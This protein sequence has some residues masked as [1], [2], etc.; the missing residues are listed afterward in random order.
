MNLY[1]MPRFGEDEE[2][3]PLH[4][5]LAVTDAPPASCRRRPT[6]LAEAGPVRCAQHQQHHSVKMRRVTRM[7]LLH[8]IRPWPENTQITA[9]GCPKALSDGVSL[10]LIALYFEMALAEWR[11]PNLGCA[12]WLQ[13]T[14][15]QIYLLSFISQRVIFNSFWVFWTDIYC[16]FSEWFFPPSLSYHR[17][18]ARNSGSHV[19]ILSK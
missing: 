18:V 1:V 15:R 16:D 14:P 12:Q 3:D 8:S 5:P 4:G 10:C 6:W 17:D 19:T 13:V 9:D 11:A 2:C 7:G